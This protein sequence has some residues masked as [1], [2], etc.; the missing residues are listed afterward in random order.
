MKGLRTWRA[1]KAWAERSAAPL[2]RPTRAYRQ[3][4]GAEVLLLVSQDNLDALTAT[5]AFAKRSREQGAV[6]HVLA[7]TSVKLTKEQAQSDDLWT[8]VDYQFNGLPKP[9]R[10]AFW[11]KRDYDLVI[12]CGLTSF[13]PFDYLAAGLTAHRRIAAY[14]TT[15]VAYDLIISPKSTDG[16]AAFLQQLTHY[17]EHLSPD[18]A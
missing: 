18:Y 16:V 8:P 1:S 17:L 10:E 6:V 3:G 7:A 13:E 11:R 14:D 5:R 2:R 4:K 15:L 9:E 12:H